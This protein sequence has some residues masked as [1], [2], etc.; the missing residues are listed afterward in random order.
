MSAGQSLLEGKDVLHF[1]PER[2]LAGI[3][4]RSARRY[5]TADFSIA[6]EQLDISEKLDMSLDISALGLANCVVD[7]VLCSPV[8]DQVCNDRLALRE[9]FRIL[10]P[11]GIALISVPIVEGWVCTYEDDAIVDRHNRIKYF[12]FDDRVRSYGRDFSKKME[13]AGFI[14]SVFQPS[15]K[16]YGEHSLVPGDKIFIG[17]RP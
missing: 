4:R 13:E 1:A 6:K 17:L 3:A 12:G 11:R 9:L 7:I 16:S 14:A 15:F 2:C 10:R 5:L 8:L